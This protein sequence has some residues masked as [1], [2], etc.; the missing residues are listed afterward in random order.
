MPIHHGKCTVIP[1]LCSLQC[2]FM[3]LSNWSLD[4]SLGRKLLSLGKMKAEGE[5]KMRHQQRCYGKQLYNDHFSDQKFLFLMSGFCGLWLLLLLLSSQSLM[6]ME[7]SN[8]LNFWFV[9]PCY[10][11]EPLSGCLLILSDWLPHCLQV[12]TFQC[13]TV[14]PPQPS[15]SWDYR[16]EPLCELSAEQL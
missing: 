14:L 4:E 8:H 6:F 9:F 7:E 1:P 2:I 15:E 10:Q 16:C 3:P 11:K 12:A 5:S 13:R